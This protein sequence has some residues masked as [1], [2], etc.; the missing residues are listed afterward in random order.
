M[1]QEAKAIAIIKQMEPE[2][3]FQKVKALE[4][5]D[6]KG[7]TKLVEVKYRVK[8]APV[9]IEKS[10]YEAY[11]KHE[12]FWLYLV[13]GDL[14]TPDKVVIEKYSKQD[15]KNKIPDEPHTIIYRFYPSGKKE[16][17]N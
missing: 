2:E 15:L 12:N 7:K 6:L 13:Y 10:E 5:Y 9:S 4:G 17:N 3:D 14:N 1:N 8:K 11:K 16:E